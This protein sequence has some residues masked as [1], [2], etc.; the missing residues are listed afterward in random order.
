METPDTTLPEIP[1]PKTQAHDTGPPDV[2]APDPPP[3]KKHGGGPSSEAGKR[4]S[5]DNSIKHGCF[6][7][8]RLMS[9]ESEEAFT[10]FYTDLYEHLAPADPEEALLADDYIWD[11]WR[12]RRAREYEVSLFDALADDPVRFNLELERL[13]RTQ[14]R[15][16][17]SRA[18]N[19][20][21]LDNLQYE[22]KQ[23]EALKQCHRPMTMAEILAD[24]GPGPEGEILEGLAFPGDP[25]GAPSSFRHPPAPPPDLPPPQA[26]MVRFPWLNFIQPAALSL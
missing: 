5:R 13:V 1:P 15:V 26:Q 19:R 4:I 11:V 21:D 2:T 3:E 6:S 9:W 20:R 16:E 10:R 17:R 7:G 18:K 23:R 14:M 12:V 24:L 8:K 25:D 22:R